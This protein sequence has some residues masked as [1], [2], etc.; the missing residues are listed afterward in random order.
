MLVSRKLQKQYG[1]ITKNLIKSMGESVKVYKEPT[2]IDC[3]NCL[4]DEI[5]QKSSGIFDSTFTTST[6]IFSGTVCQKV[7]SPKSF[8]VGRCPVC[9]GTGQLECSDRSDITALVTF[10]STDSDFLDLSGG[11]EGENTAILKADKKH[12]ALIRDAKYF[13]V[14]KNIKMELIRPPIL[15]GVGTEV[16]VV[17]DIM[18]VK[19]GHSVKKVLTDTR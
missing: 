17:A 15:R 3:P 10:R 16:L 2:T 18:T 11:R 8:T 7:I 14:K 9:K 19:P 13:E 1:V 6:T 12:Y 5:N 4:R